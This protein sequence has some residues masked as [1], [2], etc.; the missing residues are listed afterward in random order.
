MKTKAILQPFCLLAA[1]VLASGA[2]QA[3]KIVDVNCDD[4]DTVS[5]VLDK[6]ENK[7]FKAITIRIKGTCNENPTVVL[8]DLTLKPNPSVLNATI[9]GTL[10]FDGAGRFHVE[11]L[12]VTGPGVGID[13]LNGASGSIYRST[14]SDNEGSGI[15]F[16]NAVFVNI[17]DSNIEDNGLGLEANRGTGLE[18]G[19][20]SVV[21][22][23]NNMISGNNFA[24]IEA[25]QHGTISSRSD[26][27]SAHATN[28]GAWA[29]EATR[30]SFV[31]IRESEV[32]GKLVVQGQSYLLVRDTELDD[33]ADNLDGRN[34][35]LI[36]TD[37]EVTG[38]NPV[39]DATSVC[40]P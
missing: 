4:G 25:F 9:N 26:E 8:D 32:T 15:N 38:A 1:L 14:I 16:A 35:S 40:L 39:C 11:D 5:S 3:E 13:V 19:L 6:F 36:R 34:M 31:E 18:V 23:R 22:S 7:K 24:A 12:I 10:T 21:R 27:I 30:N 37:A 20:G 29:G 2:A 17:E 28:P 33:T